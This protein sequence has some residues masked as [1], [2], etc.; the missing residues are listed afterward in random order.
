VRAKGYRRESIHGLTRRVRANLS[1]LLRNRRVV[2]DGDLLN[3]RSSL[4]AETKE[5]AN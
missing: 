4:P 2:K 3:A 5:A 1:C